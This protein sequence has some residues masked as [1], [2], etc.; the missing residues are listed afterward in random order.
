MNL[1]ELSPVVLKG[2]FYMG[3]FLY[4]LC[5]SNMFG[6]RIVFGTDASHIFPQSV[7]SIIPLIVGVVVSR[8]CTLG[9]P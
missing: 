9:A 5:E 2:C 3:A 4:R 8:V 7:L 6:V 1:G